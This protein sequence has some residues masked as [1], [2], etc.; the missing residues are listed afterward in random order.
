MESP[1]IIIARLET[2]IEE[3]QARLIARTDQA[4]ETALRDAK[5]IQRLKLDLSKVNNPG[6]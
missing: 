1:F 5:T 3:L 4:M 2:Q 6:S